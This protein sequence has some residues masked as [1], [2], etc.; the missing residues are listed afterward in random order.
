MMGSKR[1]L[2]PNAMSWANRK[3]RVPQDLWSCTTQG[4]QAVTRDT[5]N[6][7]FTHTRPY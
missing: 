3:R 4:F 7:L 1:V 2:L 5:R 6:P